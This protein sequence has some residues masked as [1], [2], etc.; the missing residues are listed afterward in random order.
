MVTVKDSIHIDAPVEDVFAYMDE[1]ANQADI[2]PSLSRSELVERLPNGGSHVRWTYSM[3]GLGLTGEV[4]AI[5][6]APDERIVFEMQGGIDGTITW[7]FE[8]EEGGTRFTFDAEYD[9]P[10]PVMKRA[11]ESLVEHYN[12]R[13]VDQMLA[14]LKATMEAPEEEPSEA[15]AA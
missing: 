8:S 12:E 10:A 14:S 4:K 6:Y 2:T 7:H 9:I 1:P 11:A 13:E 5:E 3:L 15:A